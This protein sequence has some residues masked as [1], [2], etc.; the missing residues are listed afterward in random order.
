VV[1]DANNLNLIGDQT[2]IA[3]CGLDAVNP[4][5]AGSD[6]TWDMSNLIETEEQSFTYVDPQDTPWGYQF[7]TANICGINWQNEHSYY[8]FDENGITTVGYAGLTTIVDPTDTFKIVFGDD[9]NFIPIP[10]EY[11][12][13]HQDDFDGISYAFG[14]EVPFTGDVDFEVDGEGTL[15]L[16]TGTYEN[17]VRYHFNRTQVNGMG[18]GTTTQTKEQWGWMSSDH[19]FWLMIQEITN[20]G[21]SDS[22]LIWYDKNPLPAIPTGIENQTITQLELFPNP[23]SV[24]ESIYLNWPENETAQLIISDITG[25]QILSEQTVLQQGQNIIQIPNNAQSG[26]YILKLISSYGQY[27]SKIVLK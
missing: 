5:S 8:R 23:A 15:I 10:F 12:D 18:P 13:M 6:V 21:F 19:R 25:K 24:G 4:G 2:T 11:N 7:P 14:F 3:I 1:I 9:E 16:P 26:I 20:D 17:V 22:E 27:N